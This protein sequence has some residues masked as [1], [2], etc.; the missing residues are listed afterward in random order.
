MTTHT[1]G[2]IELHADTPRNAHMHRYWPRAFFL[3]YPHLIL[4]PKSFSTSNHSELS[5]DRLANLETRLR[6]IPIAV[7]HAATTLV[8]LCY[9]SPPALLTVGFVRFRL[10]DVWAFFFFFVLSRC[11]LDDT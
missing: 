6:W 4:I 1:N 9:L 8:F 3:F 2:L 10:W 5:V 11:S 7:Y